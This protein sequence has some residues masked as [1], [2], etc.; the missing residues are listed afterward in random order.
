M[1][2]GR[3][4][5]NRTEVPGKDEWK[6]KTMISRAGLRIRITLCEDLYNVRNN[7]ILQL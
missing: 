7:P 3:E 6:S 4:Q 2:A 5:S 1:H